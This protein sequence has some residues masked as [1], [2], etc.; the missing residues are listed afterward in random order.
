M[1]TEMIFEELKE[2]PYT[3]IAFAVW[4][5]TEKRVV[6]QILVD[7]AEDRAAEFMQ[8]GFHRDRQKLFR[9][10][11]MWRPLV[12]R[13]LALFLRDRCRPS[14]VEQGFMAWDFNGG[15]RRRVMNKRVR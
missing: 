4:A 5:L 13:E 10:R 1:N 3:V 15:V 7:Y 2:T 6:Y 9:K 11:Y 12:G 8:M 14:Y